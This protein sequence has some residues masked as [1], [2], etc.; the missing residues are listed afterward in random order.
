MGVSPVNQGKPIFECR[1]IFS[2]NLRTAWS[3]PSN[4]DSDGQ[5]MLYPLSMNGGLYILGSKERPMPKRNLPSCLTWISTTVFKARSIRQSIILSG[6][7]PHTYLYLQLLLIRSDGKTRLLRVKM[8]RPV[9]S[10]LR[11]TVMRTLF[12]PLW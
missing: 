9:W 12:G 6:K 2:G 1:Y 11:V 5:L 8:P 7:T 3:N 10:S 4:T